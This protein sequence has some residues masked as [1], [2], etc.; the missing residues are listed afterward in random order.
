MRG[1]TICFL[2]E[3]INVIKSQKQFG[4]VVIRIATKGVGEG[5]N[6]G[7]K[8]H[9]VHPVHPV[10]LGFLGFPGFP[11]FLEFREFQVQPEKSVQREQRAQ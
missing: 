1:G 9:P 5:E 7:S 11:E 6:E 8:V 4:V 10:H 3:D 2:G